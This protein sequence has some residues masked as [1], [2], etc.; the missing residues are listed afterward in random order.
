MAKSFPVGPGPCGNVTYGMVANQ[1]E[2]MGLAKIDYQ[3]SSKQSFFGR[4]YVTHSIVPSSFTGTELSV[5]NAGTDDE[6]NSLVLGHTYIFGPGALNTFHATLDRNG[7]T[8]FQVPIP[9]SH[10]ASAFRGFTKRCPTTRTSTS[11]ATS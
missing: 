11:R 2:Q 7:I 1:T 9:Y 4:Y 8:K 3:I 10:R 6:V 5:Q